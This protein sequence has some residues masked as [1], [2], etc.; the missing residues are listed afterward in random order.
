[1]NIEHVSLLDYD[2]SRNYRVLIASREGNLWI[3][4]KSG[5]NLEG[6]QPQRVEGRLMTPPRHHRLLGK[7]YQ[8]AI[9]A[10]GKVYLLNRRGE[11]L[12]NFPL[13]LDA[14]LAGDYYITRGRTAAET[15][16]TVV[17]RDGWR[18][19]FNLQGKVL[20]REVLVKTSLDGKFSLC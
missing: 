12:P 6:W 18:I 5:T 16:I 9:R 10:D 7:D 20:S 3:Y 17:A 19:T 2:N 8:F 1:K 15:T 11:L 4:D 14:R 13:V